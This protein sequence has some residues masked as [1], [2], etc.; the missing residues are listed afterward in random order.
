MW[1]AGSTMPTHNDDVHI[2][3][4]SQWLQWMESHPITLLRRI[5][6]FC[7]EPDTEHTRPPVELIMVWLSFHLA[8]L[9]GRWQL[10]GWC[11]ESCMNDFL[12]S[13]G[14][15][16]HSSWR[17]LWLLHCVHKML[18]LRQSAGAGAGGMGCPGGPLPLHGQRQV[19]WDPLPP[20]R[21]CPNRPK[22]CFDCSALHQRHWEAAVLVHWCL[23]CR[24]RWRG[25]DKGKY[26]DKGTIGP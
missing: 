26:T 14:W 1:C 10:L 16:H 4:I 8:L 3:S 9:F 17:C 5:F 12:P 6:G 22:F 23:Q 21:W 13:S 18:S 19:N 15:S 20:L 24:W 25:W 2:S 7:S 11:M